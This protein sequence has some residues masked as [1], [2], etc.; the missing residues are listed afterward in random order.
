M[1]LLHTPL[2]EAARAAGGRMVPSFHDV[3]SGIM[4]E[5]DPSSR[6]R[7]PMEPPIE[8][9]AL[10]RASSERFSIVRRCVASI[11]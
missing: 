9:R 4:C 1:T 3:A 5:P 10:T 6:L 8:A 11:F 2:F 7:P